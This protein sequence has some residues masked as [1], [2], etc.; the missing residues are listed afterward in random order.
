MQTLNQIAEN[1]AY[2]LGDQFNH[3]LNESIKATILDYRAKFIRDDLDRNPLSDVHFSQVGTLQFE[4]VN[5]LTEFGADY[6]C[7]NLICSD[8]ALRE[9]YRILKSKKQVP[10][11][12][13]TKS[14][15]RNPFSFVGRVDG[16]K[17]FIYTTLDKFPYVKALKYSST[18]IY[19]TV[20][21]GYLYIINNLDQCDINESLKICNVMVK[22]VFEDPSDFYNACENG[23]TFIDDMPFPIS[24]DMLVNLSNAILK[25]EYPL[26]PKDGE[27]VNIKPDDNE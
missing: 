2:K 22:G 11:P 19:Y 23:D 18:V 10:L 1:I 7:L 17:S 26:K 25:G 14:A 9:E 16:S 24:K 20:I 8:V 6:S 13:R 15:G 27:E 3:T 4:V 12:I 21:N 5:L